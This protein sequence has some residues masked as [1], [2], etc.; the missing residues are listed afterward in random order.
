MFRI[1]LLLVILCVLPLAVL[2]AEEKLVFSTSE[3]PPY[4]SHSMKHNGFLT[5]MIQ[6]SFRL[7]P[8]PVEIEV[9]FMP[10]KQAYSE[11]KKGN[12]AGTFT[13]ALNKKHQAHFHF[14]DAVGDDVPTF[15]TYD[16]KVPH[17]WKRLSDL[18]KYRIGATS[19]YTYTKDFWNA[20]KRKWLK[21]EEDESDKNNMKK[22]VAGKIDLLP[23]DPHVAHHLIHCYYNKKRL[24]FSWLTPPLNT[25]SVHVLF[26]K[27]VAGS[28]NHVRNFN[29]GLEK[30]SK[31]GGLQKIYEQ[32]KAG[33]YLTHCDEG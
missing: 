33:E 24:R 26:S 29:A 25:V 9:K 20:K 12:Y 2:N 30:L 23:I 19:G 16:G 11:A 31:S 14:S 21:I 10:W 32:V 17:T 27:K 18:Q 3:Y 22:L 8:D 7:A 5:R 28:Q 6:E 15:L 1:K 13:W 4:I